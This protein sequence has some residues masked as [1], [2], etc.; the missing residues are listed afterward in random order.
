MPGWRAVMQVLPATAR[1]LR[2][3]EPDWLL[4][5]PSDVPPGG[6]RDALPARWP[7]Q[8]AEL[9]VGTRPFALMPLKNKTRFAR[10]QGAEW[11]G[12]F[13][14]GYEYVYENKEFLLVQ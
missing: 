4:F 2:D 5:P 6:L 11:N 1:A 7:E 13:I 14:P 8:P 12:E 3:R 10:R 9:L